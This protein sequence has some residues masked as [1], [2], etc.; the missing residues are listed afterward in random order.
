MKNILEVRKAL[1]ARKPTFRQQTSH[2][3]ARVN[4]GWRRSKGSDSKMRLGL[5]GY[6]RSAC[7]GWRSPAA[8]RG[9][10]PTGL[11]IVTVH[12]PKDVEKI[13]PKT[14]GAL[15]SG[16]MGIKKQ[17]VCIAALQKKNIRIL[18]VKD[19][20]AWV[21]ATKKKR[22]EEKAKMRAQSKVKEVKKPAPAKKTETSTEANQEE[23]K[24]Q[25]RIEQEKIITKGK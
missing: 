8:V 3:R 20:S 15:L 22:E 9:L 11:E 19:A 13:N 7:I 2:K 14:Q 21:L 6:S 12:N 23:K 18:N 1:K 10:H 16:A 17:W 24:E 5:K 25:E 4:P